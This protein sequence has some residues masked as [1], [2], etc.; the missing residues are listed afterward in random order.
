MHGQKNIKAF[1]DVEAN[2]GWVFNAT[3]RPL[4]AGEGDVLDIVEETGWAPW[5]VWT[6]MG[7]LA[8]T[9]I[10]SR[11][12]PPRSESLYRLTENRSTRRKIYPIATSSTQ[13]STWTALGRD[14]DLRGDM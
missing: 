5:M 11:V 12:R 6:G 9:G 7:I 8:S 1:F 13:T 14:S 4:Y 10:R 2:W 3:H